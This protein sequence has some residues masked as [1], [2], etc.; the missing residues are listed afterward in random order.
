MQ[1]VFKTDEMAPAI[2]NASKGE[3]DIE[4]MID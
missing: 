1:M 3:R 2:T 4:L